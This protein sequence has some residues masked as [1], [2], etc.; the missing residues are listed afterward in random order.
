LSV[1]YV[2][3]NLSLRDILAEGVGHLLSKQWKIRD[4]I[5]HK[6]KNHMKI[7]N[8]DALF[9]LLCDIE[10]FL[11]LCHKNNLL[12]A[13]GGFLDDLVVWTS[14]NS[15][16]IASFWEFPLGTT[17]YYGLKLYAGFSGFS[18]VRAGRRP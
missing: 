7:P 16:L 11:H 13:S 9:G 2:I 3:V 1:A 14:L 5:F 4:Y 17:S 12:Y 6:P 18:I 8:K 15:G 10:D